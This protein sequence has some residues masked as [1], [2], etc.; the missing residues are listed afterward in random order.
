MSAVDSES[1]RALLLTPAEDVLLMRVSGDREGRRLWITPGGR[2]EP[3]ES[4]DAALQRELHE[5]LG[6]DGI[7]IGAELWTWQNVVVRAGRRITE[8]ERAFLVETSRFEPTALHMTEDERRRHRGFRW[9]RADEIASCR[10]V[11][12]PRRLDALLPDL[13]RDGPPP[14]PRCVDGLSPE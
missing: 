6:L 1:V 10:D 4:P 5:E 13:L 11:F 14:T 2:R 12:V 9:W 7:R 8:R 3:G